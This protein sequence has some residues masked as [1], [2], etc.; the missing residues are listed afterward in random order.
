MFTQRRK[1]KCL[2]SQRNCLLV[3]FPSLHKI[4][5]KAQCVRVAY[6][7][8]TNRRALIIFNNA[9]ARVREVWSH[10]ER[11]LTASGINFEAHQTTHAGDATTRTRAGLKEGFGTIAV[12]GGDGTL[13]EAA[14]GFFEFPNRIDS[15][16]MPVALNPQASLAIIPAGTGNDLA[17]GLAGGREPMDN[18]LAALVAH[19]RGEGRHFRVIDALYGTSD[20][21]ER[22][23]ICIN[24][25]TFGIGAEVA[26]RVAAQKNFIR[27]FSGE[28][29]FV[30]GAFGALLAW[31]ERP[32][33]VTI[34]GEV[35][36]MS[37]NLL[38]VAN[39]ICA[40]GGM[41]FA[42]EAK[43]DDGLMDVLLSSNLTRASILRELKRIRTGDHLKN[44]NVRSMKAMR[45]IV[46]HLTPNDP[47]PL[48]AD[49]NVRGHTPAEFRIMPKAIQLV[50]PEQAEGKGERQ[51]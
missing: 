5:K 34:D 41:M 50:L 30:A 29:R 3:Y 17:R 40:G 47:L 27:K 22:K 23:F 36:E 24:A 44:P 31:R 33:R 14:S 4:T 46:E 20:G 18:W 2:S 35:T 51:K 1:G 6:G 45:V 9:A 39:N 32:V 10:I 28:A 43:L 8:N 21:G 13:S 26:A 16:E 48:E 37:T 38:A 19:C 42:P 25:A 15:D 11:A 49:G 7:M 12:V